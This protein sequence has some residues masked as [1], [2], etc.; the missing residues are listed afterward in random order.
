MSLSP[1][2]A[3][4]NTKTTIEDY[5]GDGYPDIVRQE[6]ECT[7]QIRRS[8]IKRTNKLKTVITPLGAEYTVDYKLAPS[9]YDMPNSKWVVSKL[10]VYDPYATAAEGPSTMNKKF[11]F[12]NG[13]YDR[14]ER[15]FT[16]FNMLE[17]LTYIMIILSTDKILIDTII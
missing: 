10:D 5:D 4:N 13:R 11:E 14:R 2:R 15:D 17:L 9:N 12:H 7:L 3:V 1:N 8:K 16:D 6:D